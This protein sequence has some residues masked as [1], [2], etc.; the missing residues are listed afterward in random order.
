MTSQAAISATKRWSAGASALRET[1]APVEIVVLLPK[2][3]L[4]RQ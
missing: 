4:S 1:D 2:L 3:P